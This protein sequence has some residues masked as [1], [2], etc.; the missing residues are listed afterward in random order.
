VIER[1]LGIGTAMPGDRR[2][3][4]WTRALAEALADRD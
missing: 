2:Q 3:Q 4:E 1:Y